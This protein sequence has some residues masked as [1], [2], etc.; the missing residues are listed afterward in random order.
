MISLLNVTAGREDE[1][2]PDKSMFKRCLLN[3][4]DGD[5]D[6]T[7]DGYIMGSELGM[8]LSDKAVNY[9]DRSQHLQYGKISN[10]DQD[11]GDFI[12]VP[13]SNP[14]LYALL[15]FAFAFSTFKGDNNIPGLNTVWIDEIRLECYS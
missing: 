8:C 11:R 5:A 6:L 15:N 3:G 7:S 14:D 4:P 13:L 2:V 12:F 10:P 1:E 9:T